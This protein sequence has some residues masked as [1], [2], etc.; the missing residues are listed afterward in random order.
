MDN[1]VLK[2]ELLRQWRFRNP[3]KVVRWLLLLGGVATLVG[4]NLYLRPVSESGVTGF[5]NIF[6]ELVY[7]QLF[8]VCVL[9]PA[10]YSNLFTREREQRTFEALLL[11]RLT[12]AQ[13]CVGKLLARQ[14]TVVLALLCGLP[15][16]GFCAVKGG[17]P[18]WSCAGCYAVLLVCSATFG[19]YGVTNS[20]AVR[21]TQLATVI[22][23]AST[24]ILWPLFLLV[25]QA[26]VRSDTFPA[27][28]WGYVWEV[29]PFTAVAALAT[30]ERS[31][32]FAW[33]PGWSNWLHTLVWF[34]IGARLLL[35]GLSV[36]LRRLPPERV[37]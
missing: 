28:L 36:D 5:R 31:A 9:S 25:L 34:G 26:L 32:R 19:V 37:A 8:G 30:P 24:G 6:F 12:S 35:V 2:R 1:P 3:R 29:Q 33:L 27:A 11:T 10:F 14:S 22:N 16:T 23:I 7:L 15:L 13:I 18:A 4:L 21:R 17:V 20:F